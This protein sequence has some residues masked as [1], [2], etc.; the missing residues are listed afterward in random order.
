VYPIDIPRAIRKLKELAPNIIWYKELNQASQLLITKE[1]T[2]TLSA[3]GR[4]QQAID[5]GAPIKLVWN[6]AVLVFD[7]WFVLRGSPNKDN[8]LHFVAF[9]SQPKPQADLARLIPYAPTNP[10]AYAY[11]DKATAEKLPTY[12]ENV[13]LTIT[14]NASWWKDH[15][16]E[17]IKACREAVIR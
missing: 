14:K 15:G 17:W 10:R 4:L 7:L 8:A 16:Q 3:N 1:A 11:L 12:P 5:Q 2:I 9:A 6:E 13:K